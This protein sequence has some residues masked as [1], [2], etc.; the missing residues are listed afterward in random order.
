MKFLAILSVAFLIACGGGEAVAA[1]SVP[2][3]VKFEKMPGKE[4]VRLERANHGGSWTVVATGNDAQVAIYDCPGTGTQFL[5]YD[6]R[7]FAWYSPVPSWGLPAAAGHFAVLTRA[8]IDLSVPMYR[9]RGP[10]FSPSWGVSGEYYARN[11]AVTTSRCQDGPGNYGSIPCPE[12]GTA[13]ARANPMQLVDLAGE[14]FYSVGIHAAQGNIAYSVT[15][16]KTHEQAVQA[17]TESTNP[18]ILTGNKIVF[19]LLCNGDCHGLGRT[20]VLHLSGIAAGWF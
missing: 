1:C 13:P 9:A 19:A 17:W 20:Y 14:D 2:L 10:M 7:S 11:A 8:D 6:M 15:S 5:V 18:A 16:S 3:D 4:L 12:D